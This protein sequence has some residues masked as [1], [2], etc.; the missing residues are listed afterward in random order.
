MIPNFLYYIAPTII[1]LISIRKY[2]SSKWGKCKNQ[3]RLDGKL[4]IVTGANCGLGYEIAKELC[5]R[6]V[7]V[8]LACRNQSAGQQAIARIKKEVSITSNQVMNV[9]QSNLANN[10]YFCFRSASN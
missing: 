4:A 9:K 8:I 2:R 3:K 7:N 5:N 10:L 1:V 6:G